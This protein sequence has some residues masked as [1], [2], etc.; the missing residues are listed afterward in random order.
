M[1]M[2]ALSTVHGRKLIKEA[3]PKDPK[4]KAKHEDL[5]ASPGDTFD[6]DDFGIGEIERKAMIANGAARRKT[7]EVA[8]DS[9]PETRANGRA[10]AGS[11]QVS[12]DP[13]E[14]LNDAELQ[15]RVLDLGLTLPEPSSRVQMI[16]ALKAA[17]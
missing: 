9:G 6:T 13:L 2:I 1:K 12:E 17:A 8:D 4:S 16:A 11:R 10:A 15:A 3:D 5:I 14:K 7:R